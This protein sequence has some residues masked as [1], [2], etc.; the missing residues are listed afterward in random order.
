[1]TAGGMR[2]L[3]IDSDSWCVVLCVAGI[4]IKLYNVYLEHILCVLGA[5]F[6]LPGRFV[7]NTVL[8]IICCFL[9]AVMCLHM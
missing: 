6:V 7:S 8:V 3:Y 2:F 1:M 4:I 5:S 9:S